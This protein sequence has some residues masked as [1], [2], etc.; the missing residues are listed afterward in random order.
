MEQRLKYMLLKILDSGGNVDSLE[1]AG[2]QYAAIANA[3]S[4]IINEKLIV[5]DEN[6][7]FVLS[8]EGY[9]QMMELSEIINKNGY[10]KIEPYVEYK[11]NK[12]GKYD[13]FIE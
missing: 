4:Q 5:P 2:Y 13:I 6:F 11:I 1:K 10:W 12:I 8:E 9:N 3:Y 7:K